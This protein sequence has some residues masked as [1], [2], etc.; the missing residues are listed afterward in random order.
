MKY[1]HS[2]NS[3][4]KKLDESFVP[5]IKPILVFTSDEAEL[6]IGDSPIPAMKMK[7]LKE[8]MRQGGKNRVLTSDQIAK[9][10]SLFEQE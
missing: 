3:L 6:E 4:R 1:K 7:Q 9:I 5:E 8:F 2:R 10:T